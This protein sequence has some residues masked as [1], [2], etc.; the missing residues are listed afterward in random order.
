MITEDVLCKKIECRMVE[1]GISGYKLAEITGINRST[2][3]R[4]LNRKISLRSDYLL[5]ILDCLALELTIAPCQS[6]RT[7]CKE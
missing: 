3:S 2:I 7:S 5:T 4:F 1:L 6:S